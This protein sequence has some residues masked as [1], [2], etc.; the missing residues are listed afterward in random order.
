MA[1]AGAVVGPGPVLFVEVALDALLW[2]L[3]KLLLQNLK[4]GHLAVGGH[5]LVEL[6]AVLLHH[7]LEVFV[8]EAQELRLVVVGMDEAHEFV[9]P[10][11]NDALADEGQRVE[12][13]LDL[14]GIDVLAVG[15]EEHVLGSAVDIDIA[16]GVHRAEVAR[17][18]PSLG[19]DRRLGGLG[20]LV[21]AQQD[22]GTLVRISPGTL[23]GSL[24]SMR[25]SWW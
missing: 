13:V 3:L 22:V 16:V 24:L 18:E 25:T 23:A 20:I 5:H 2:C 7:A 4:F 12:L 15:S 6:L 21:V 1:G 9:A 10:L 14:L 8:V 11:H 17:V 19:V